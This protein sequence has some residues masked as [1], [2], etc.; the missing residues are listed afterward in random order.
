[1]HGRCGI[2]CA[3]SL[4]RCSDPHHL[5][6]Y[7]LARRRSHFNARNDKRVSAAHLRKCRRRGES[8]RRRKTGGHNQD[9]RGTSRR[10][11]GQ[12]QHN[13]LTHRAFYAPFFDEPKI[14][15]RILLER[16]NNWNGYKR[17]KA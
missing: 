16:L 3:R 13:K 6:R 2:D 5:T 15:Y 4:A 9:R 17:N 8:R 7:A 1:M 10:R 11:A 12:T 14:T